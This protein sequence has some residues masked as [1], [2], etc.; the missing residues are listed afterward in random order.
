MAL[1]EASTAFAQAVTAPVAV[2][3][4]STEAVT[5]LADVAEVPAG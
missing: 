3:T 2:T 4:T 5:A 1:A